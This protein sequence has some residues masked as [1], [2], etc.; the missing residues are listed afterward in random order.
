M[1]HEAVL[2]LERAMD[3]LGPLADRLVFVGG[4]VIPLLIE[5]DFAADA[6][7]TVDVDCVVSARTYGQFHEIEQALRELDFA[8]GREPGDPICRYRRGELILDVLP[9][10]DLGFGY[11][12]WYERGVRTSRRVTLPS[13]RSI[14]VFRPAYLFASKVVAFRDRGAADPLSSDDLADLILL[15]EG[16]PTLLDD[17]TALDDPDLPAE[18][19]RWAEEMLH[20]PD[21]NDLVDGHLARTATRGRTWIRRRIQELADMRGRMRP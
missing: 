4:A 15:L 14:Q 12:L 16:C 8:S 6:R 17:A 2:L 9:V 5:P 21:L 18:L 10:R 13:G 1:S 20:R 11:N 3:A 7:P 19:A